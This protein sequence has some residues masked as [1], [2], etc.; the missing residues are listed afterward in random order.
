MEARDNLER[1]EH[2]RW[3]TCANKVARLYD[4]ANPKG[5]LYPHNEEF[6]QE[7]TRR[8]AVY[9]EARKVV[10]SKWELLVES[11][12]EAV[13]EVPEVIGRVAKQTAGAAAGVITSPAKLAAV[14]LGSAI[15]LPPI[16]RAFRK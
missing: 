13:A 16:I 7:C 12:V 9:L 15:L 8:L 14:L 10:P 2:A 4:R 6:W 11:F 1:L 3:K 5:G